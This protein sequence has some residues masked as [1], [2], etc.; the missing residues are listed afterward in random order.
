VISECSVCHGTSLPLTVDGPHGMHNVNSQAWVK[1]HKT[2]V[3]QRGMA[4]CQACHGLKLEG[5]YLAK[6]PV[7]RTFQVEDSKTVRIPAGTSVSCTLCH[8]NPM[9]H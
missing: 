1:D 8:E 2:L 4:N 5:T 9:N 3:E 7:A 6:V